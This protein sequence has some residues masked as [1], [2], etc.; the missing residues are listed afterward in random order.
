[1]KVYITSLF[2]LL[3]VFVFGQDK[4]L[5]ITNDKDVSVDVT[6]YDISVNYV[7][8]ITLEP[9]KSTEYRFTDDVSFRLNYSSETDEKNDVCVL[10][11]TQIYSQF[12]IQ[13]IVYKEMYTTQRNSHF[14]LVQKLCDLP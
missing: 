14:N 6:I 3:T 1:M 5:R 7:D 12:H 4:T 13:N 8:V 2:L 9:K 11:P 10:T